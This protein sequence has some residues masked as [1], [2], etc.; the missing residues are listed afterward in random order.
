MV[1]INLSARKDEEARVRPR[2]RA[3]ARAAVSR[4]AGACDLGQLV[5]PMPQSV[6][7]DVALALRGGDTMAK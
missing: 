5:A 3:D 2:P 7:I 1:Y 4:R 6:P